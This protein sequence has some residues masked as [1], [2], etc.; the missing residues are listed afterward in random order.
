[1]SS[2]PL[3][4]HLRQVRRASER[5]LGREG[6]IGLDRNERVSPIPE[7]LFREM[8]AAL[9]MEDLTAYPD[10][11]SFVARL[12]AQVGLPEDHIAETAGADAGIRRIFMAYLRPGESVVMLNPAYSMYELYARIFQ[13]ELKRVDYRKDRRCDVAAILAAVQ[14]G[15]RIVILA[16]PNQPTGTAIDTADVRGI[17]ARA[18]EVGAVCV[19]DEAYHPFHPATV[20]PLVK[21]FDNLVVLRSFSKYPGCAGIRIGYALAVP[22]LI[23]GLMSVRGGSEV[24]GVSLAFACYLLDHPEIAEDFRLAA[25]AGRRMV[26]EAASRLGLEPLACVTNFQLLRCRQDDGAKAIAAA[27]KRRRYLVRADFKHPSLENCLR[28]SLNGPDVM[29]QFIAALADS[30]LEVRIGDHGRNSVP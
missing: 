25:E 23:Q 2:P 3:K 4:D 14:P 16:N 15:V 19:I 22:S 5:H 12:S 28:I 21:D 27:L 13:G 30:V 20:A 10:A 8:L 9:T 17:V 1:M 24:S 6:F 26:D 18:G 7:P 11:G 29:T